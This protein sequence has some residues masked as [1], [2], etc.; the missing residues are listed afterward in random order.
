[1]KNVF[2]YIVFVLV[3]PCVFGCGD[4]DY[5]KDKSDSENTDADTDSDSDAD[6]DSDT[7]A[8][9]GDPGTLVSPSGDVVEG[10][11]GVSID[12]PAG[13]LDAEVEI[14]ITPITVPEDVDAVGPA[15]EL[16][17][18]GTTFAT[19]VE[20]TLPYDPELVQGDESL[21]RIWL[22]DPETDTWEILDGSIDTE[23]Q[24]VTGEATH[25]TSTFARQV[26]TDGTTKQFQ[27]VHIG[28]PG[29]VVS[30][31]NWIKAP[32]ATPF[33]NCATFEYLTL[34]SDLS[35]LLGLEKMTSVTEMLVMQG[36]QL[37][38]LEA[39]S[40]L[41]RVAGYFVI[42]D[43]PTL[44]TCEATALAERVYQDGCIARIERNDDEATCDLPRGEPCPCDPWYVCV[45]C[46]NAS[47]RVCTPECTMG[48]DCISWGR[49]SRRIRPAAT[50]WPV[51]F[52]KVIYLG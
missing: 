30:G 33:A 14:T 42:Q 24:T 22:G 5:G 52:N 1:M 28:G 50:W 37:T 15:Y 48:M 32:D 44:P 31:A 45:D 51:P 25:F 43:N 12:I 17:P 11:D 13:A 38:D 27:S 41:N 19:P 23:N 47:N 4:D 49:T 7:N 6:S 29:E 20:V 40:N 34:K 3:S 26:C 18:D 16:G 36:T 10:P 39:L 35:S 9:A 46:P 21:V 2:I 8:D